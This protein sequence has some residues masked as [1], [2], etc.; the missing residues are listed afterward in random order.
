MAVTS[1]VSSCSLVKARER[2][3]TGEEAHE[4][5]GV[6]GD[7]VGRELV[8]ESTIGQ[9]AITGEGKEGTGV[10]LHCERRSWSAS[11]SSRRRKGGTHWQ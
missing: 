11:C 2:E 5:H 8:E 1:F 10:G 6:N 9:S 3:R 4:P 7:L